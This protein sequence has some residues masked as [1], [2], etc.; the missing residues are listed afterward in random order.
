M[1]QQ[2]N[3]FAMTGQP[4]GSF[5]NGATYGMGS[6]NANSMGSLQHGAAEQW[7]G[8]VTPADV[9]GRLG[10]TPP[11]TPHR[12][13]SPRMRSTL[14]LPS[15]SLS[16]RRRNRDDNADRRSR[17]REDHRGQQPDEQPLPAGWGQRMLNAEMRIRSLESDL[18]EAKKIIETNS[19]DIFK[20]VDQMKV[21]VQEV[22][23]RF[24]QWERAVP[25]RLHELERREEGTKAIINQLTMDIQAK[26]SELEKAI[27][28]R[29]IPPIPA[30]FGG[31]A[32]SGP[33]HFHVGSPLSG[34]DADQNPPGLDP[35]GKYAAS[36]SAHLGHG[37]APPTPG[38]PQASSPALA[39]KPWDQKVWS[40]VESK[41]SKELKPFDGTNAKYR[42]WADR[43]RDHYQK[44]HGDWE[45]LF[46]E[47]EK[48][49]API[50][51]D[52]LI[53][54]FIA[55]DDC[56][57][58]VDLAFCSNSLWTFIG[59]NVVDTIYNTRSVLA[60]GCK[61]GLELWRALYV[62]H[63]GG[64]DQVELGGINN[65]H[66]FPQCDKVESLQFWIGKWQETKDMYGAGITDVHLRSMFINIL[67]ASVQKEI[68][69][70]PELTTLQSCINHVLSDL[71]RL[72]DVSLSKL[73][74]D[75]LKAS[76][77][78]SH[79]IN[80]L[81]ETNEDDADDKSQGKPKYEDVFKSAINALSDKLDNVVAAVARPKARAKAGPNRRPSD[82]AKF[83][84]KC[85]HCGSEKHRA[86][87]CQMIKKLRA[88]NGG[89]T[90][91]GYKS[92]F[93]KWKE[94]QPKSVAAI[95]EDD[96]DGE[97]SETDLEPCWS[98]TGRCCAV[99]LC[100]P[101]ES[102][103]FDH[104]NS[105]QALFD[106][107]D[108][109]DDEDDAG[110]LN[111]L[112]Q[113]S[114]KITIGPKKSQKIRKNLSRP[115]DK[116]TIASIAKQVRDGKL[117][118]PDL[119]LDSNDQYDA[120]WA[121]VDS[122]AARSCARRKQHF[123]NTITHLKPSAVRMATA[124]GEEL[125]SRGCFKL[126]AR[127]AEGHR[128]V[129]TFEDADVDMPIMSVVE[130]SENGELGSDVVFRKSDGAILDVKHETSSRF[131]KRR[132]VYFMKLYVPRNRAD[133]A[134]FARPGQA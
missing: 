91:P 12:S 44:K 110:V 92:A 17:E 90:P 83:G 14:T 94:K 73:H 22:E 120:V 89:K 107:D 122:G 16:A 117:D 50:T 101:C 88:D 34:P 31:N 118:L 129:Q 28:T 21:F 47:V 119:T 86:K 9:G 108:F 104:H 11:V 41:V 67:P 69:E 130:L 100:G 23:G 38:F 3:P 20:R 27:N 125:K 70:K 43:V 19:I 40:I 62:K 55:T 75:R 63:E 32:T 46:K 114:S 103:S 132:G 36:Q 6:T 48:Q 113:I 53:F 97:F 87:D 58:D 30:S 33:T 133:P 2:P 1:A 76:L 79:R 65:L 42:I 115:L 78:S 84:D 99:P 37:S 74:S 85:L 123:P 128:I 13:T 5:G 7:R 26:F 77:S 81:T 93:D 56:N 51:K 96:E 80:S 49:K 82:F 64:A 4:H 25:E 116:R 105:F 35:W 10:M 66:N 72:N 18:L 29:P 52:K 59:E 68:R 57:F 8:L 112:K 60:G 98:I 95:T 24:G 106:S 102:P 15:R 111:A 121:L 109:D 71:G 134:G 124:S 45:F 54:T 39:R 127:S 61:N 126:E 131:V